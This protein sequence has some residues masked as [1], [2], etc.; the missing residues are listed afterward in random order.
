M[1]RDTGMSTNAA[2]VMDAPVRQAASGPEGY[3]P[4]GAGMPYPR[5]SPWPLALVVAI[6][7]AFAFVL[8]TYRTETPLPVAPPILVSL[9]SPEP[10]AE[11]PKPE[12][13]PPQVIKPVPKPVKKI[14]EPQPQKPEPVAEPEPRL[15][16][17]AP[18]T[19]SAPPAPAVA[20]TL[21]APV[22]EAAPQPAAEPARPAEVVQREEPLESPRFNADYLDNP[23]PG[24]PP[25]SRRLGEQGRVLLRVH[26]AAG[27]TAKAV[28]LHKSSGHSRL[29]EI[30][31]D[32]VRRWK[33]VPARQGSQPVDAWVI[34]PI[35]FSLRG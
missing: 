31:A 12:I 17:Q 22:A 3:A 19:A 18:E 2:A 5:L 33:F 26:V 8:A 16:S 6:H 20:E 30:A 32:T 27:G 28:V 35:Q 9:V 11:E 29:D 21:S 1:R 25:L 34:V 10:A 24:Y 7:G 4:S 14:V 13:Q 15:V 23:T